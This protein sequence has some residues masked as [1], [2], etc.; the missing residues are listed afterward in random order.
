MQKLT[1]IAP[2]SDK[3]EEKTPKNL[4]KLNQEKSLEN[5]IEITVVKLSSKVEQPKGYIKP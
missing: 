2:K 1:K 4:E 5:L 3:M